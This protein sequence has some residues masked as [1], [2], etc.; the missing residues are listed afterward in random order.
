MKVASM[1]LAFALWSAPVAAHEGTT[2]V[3]LSR[4]SCRRS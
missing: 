1:L 2:H 3:A 4:Q